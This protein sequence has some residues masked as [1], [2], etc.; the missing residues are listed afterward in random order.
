MPRRREDDHARFWSRVRKS[1][2]DGCW[3]WTHTMSKGYGVIKMRGKAMHAHRAA[4]ILA[5]GPIPDGLFVCHACDNRPCVR[6]SHLF[7]GTHTD[8]MRDMHQKRP[9]WQ[10][11]SQAKL[12]TDECLSIRQHRQSGSTLTAIAAKYNVSHAAI[13]KALKWVERQDGER[14]QS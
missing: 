1:D 9:V 12:T 8:N 3:E 13:I 2:G 5:N 10:R 14:L 7:L 4:W 6:L 11:A